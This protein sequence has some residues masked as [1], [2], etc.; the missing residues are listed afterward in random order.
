MNWPPKLHVTGN[1]GDSVRRW[2]AG[3]VKATSND[4]AQAERQE[5]K[6][7]GVLW[8]MSF[9]QA[10]E[11][12]AAEKKPI[13]I[14][15]TGVNCANCR[16]MER[17]VLATARCR[18]GAQE[19]RNRPALYR[20]CTDQVDHARN[21]AR[22]WPRLTKSTSSSWPRKQPIRSTSCFRPM[23]R[24]SPEWAAITTHPSSSTS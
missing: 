11:L 8:G 3:G 5:K 4:P 22:S 15:F 13:L 2:F 19:V 7:H 12:A 6:A 14:D 1:A 23:V 16:L 10:R 21:S 9:D 17:R 24:C 20:L 18:L